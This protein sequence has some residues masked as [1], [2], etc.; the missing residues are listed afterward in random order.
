[1]KALGILLAAVVLSFSVLAA[2]QTSPGPPTTRQS[3]QY[4]PGFD[5]T[6]NKPFGVVSYSESMLTNTFGIKGLNLVGVG[7]AGIEMGSAGMLT[8][9]GFGLTAS[10]GKVNLLAAFGQAAF[11]G[12]VPHEVGFVGLTGTL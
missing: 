11:S 5:F 9:I 2:G 1:L 6:S 10:I 7:F 3:F 8:G 4:V 12:S